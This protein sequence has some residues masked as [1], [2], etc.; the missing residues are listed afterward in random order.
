MNRDVPFTDT[1]VHFWDLRHPSL[2]YDWLTP[3]ADDARLGDIAGIKSQ[4]YWPEDFAAESRFHAICHV[5]H[6]QAAI[7]SKDPVEET[8]WLQQLADAHGVPDGIVGYVDLASPDAEAVIRR[9]ARYAN[10]RGVR[11]LRRGD[12]FENEDWQR[13]YSLLDAFDLVCCDATPLERM[14][15]AAEFVRRYPAT[16][17]CVDHAGYPTRRDRSYFS[18]WSRGLR[19]IAKAAN[20]IVK[21]SALGTYDHHWTL[22]SLRPWVL[23]CIDAFGVERVVFGTNWPV[24]RLFSGYAD[25]VDAYRTIVDDFS[26]AEQLALLSGNAEH[27]FRLG[28]QPRQP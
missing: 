8:R 14:E 5:V 15:T 1:H 4:R 24:D 9:H 22:D 16:V 26:D 20:T 11:D 19:Q 28:S 27:V 10:F 3:G 23:E 2:R 7:G 12:Y 18:A 6:V 21:I 17:Y 13:G 25:L